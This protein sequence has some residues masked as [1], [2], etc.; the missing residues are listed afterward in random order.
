MIFVHI[1]LAIAALGFTSPL[2]QSIPGRLKSLG[3]QQGK[4]HWLLNILMTLHNY[5]KVM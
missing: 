2:S 3:I 4:F 5:K 1:I